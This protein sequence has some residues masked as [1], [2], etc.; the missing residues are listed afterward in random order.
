M[1]PRA[2]AKEQPVGAIEAA[3]ARAGAARFVVDLGHLRVFWRPGLGTVAEEQEYDTAAPNMWVPKTDK[4][5]DAA[6]GS[7]A[8]GTRRLELEPLIDL[9]EQRAIWRPA[10]LTDVGERGGESLVTCVNRPQMP[11]LSTPRPDTPPLLTSLD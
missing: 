10:V 9:S 3:L 1:E 4:S 11:A 5:D 8:G 2:G 7:D 6:A